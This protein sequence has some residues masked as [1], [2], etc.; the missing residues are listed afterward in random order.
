MR[1][2]VLDVLKL[3]PQAPP[4]PSSD[5]LTWDRVEVQG[6]TARYGVG[7]APDG[8]PVLFLH[9]WA[10]GSRAYKRAV[11]RLTMRGCRVYAPAMPSFGGTADLPNEHM[12][13]AGYSAWV[14][15]FLTKVGVDEPALVIGHSF[16]GGVATKLAHDRPERV[17]YLVLLNAV[18]GV[19]PRPPWEWMLGFTRELWPVPQGL[20]MVQAMRDDLVPN[21]LRNPIGL[22]RAGRLAQDADL[23][24]ELIEIRERGTPVLVLTSDGDGVIPHAA[25]EALC[26]AVGAEGRVVSGRHSWLLADPDTFGEVLATVIEVQVA[27]RRASTASTRA[28]DIAA[29]LGSAGMPVR[30]ARKL[31]RDASPLWLM[32]ESTDV[33]AADLALCHPKLRGDEVRAVARAIEG[34]SAIRLTVVAADRPGLLADSA[35]VL[36]WHRLSIARASATTWPGGL[37]L[38][39]LTIEPPDP[40]DDEAWRALG[41]D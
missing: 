37:A 38:H 35:A 36:A 31:V 13:I 14:D 9:G 20:E 1:R 24:P 17:R 25:F 40:L 18:G 23:V 28:G 41:D 11:R 19:S 5:D 2:T 8:A 10:L 15:A 6:R 12:N 39:A 4:R 34:S 7:G 27:E 22:L 32:S 3:P 29:L 33:L 26:D 30:M 16:G 21:L